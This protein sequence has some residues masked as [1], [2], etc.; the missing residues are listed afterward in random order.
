MTYKIRPRE[1]YKPQTYDQFEI[2]NGTQFIGWL[3]KSR[4]NCIPILYITAQDHKIDK[5]ALA[6]EV[7]KV[8]PNSW[9]AFFL[10]T[11]YVTFEDLE[12]PEKQ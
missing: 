9:G 7:K 4:T 8:D 2:L 3:M 10:V 12:E 1:G 11:E 6:V 5:H